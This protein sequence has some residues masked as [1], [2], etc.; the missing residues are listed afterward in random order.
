MTRAAQLSLV[1]TLI[2]LFV[3]LEL[4]R[5]RRLQERY[6]LLW[7]ATALAMCLLAGWSGLLGELASLL[8][9]AYPPN[10]LFLVVGGFSLVVLL[11]YSIV[12]SRLSEQST[13]LAQRLALLEERV[14]SAAPTV[15]VAP[16]VS[17]RGLEI[18][19]GT[20]DY[21]VFQQVF[22]EQHYGAL[23]PE[24]DARLIIDCGANVG[25]ASAWM[26][27]RYPNSEVVAIEPAVENA[28]VAVR[29]LAPYGS[30]A[31]VL[32]GAVW[33]R[34]ARLRVVRGGF[35]DGRAWSYQVREASDHELPDTATIDLG[36][37]I[38]TRDVDILKVDIECG[39]A[40]MFA[41]DPVWLRQVRNLAIE[42]HD[43]DCAANV[44]RTLDRYAFQRIDRGDTIVCLGMTRR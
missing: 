36:S 27:D 30:R 42:V 24:L 23:P 18:R 12:I 20:S 25:Y 39:E 6:S 14:A 16:D 35:R 9:I 29:N 3:V 1:A 2:V 10:A 15:A 38:G 32:A 22:I 4:V 37:L 26:L 19:I 40:D 13:R 11:H 8:G 34:A 28:A 33:P 7:I 5:R 21:D 43:A 44:E 41:D 31:T 17:D